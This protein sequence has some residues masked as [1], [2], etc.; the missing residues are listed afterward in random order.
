MQSQ[1]RPGGKNKKYS[2]RLPDLLFKVVSLDGAAQLPEGLLFWE[3]SVEILFKPLALVCL[4]FA[5]DVV[6]NS[7]P[8]T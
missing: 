6:Q 8:L 3:R 4:H 5:G 2:F 7:N 1:V